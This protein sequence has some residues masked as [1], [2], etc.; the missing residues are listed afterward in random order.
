MAHLPIGTKI[1]ATVRARS[2]PSPR[3]RTPARIQTSTNPK[4]PSSSSNHCRK[5]HYDAMLSVSDWPTS[6]V[7]IPTI[8]TTT[9]CYRQCPHHKNVTLNLM[10]SGGSASSVIQRASSVSVRTN[11]TAPSVSRYSPS[12]T[13]MMPM[14]FLR[15]LP[16]VASHTGDVA[17]PSTEN[18]ATADRAEQINP[19]LM[20]HYPTRPP[21]AKSS[22]RAGNRP[23]TSLR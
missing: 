19:R 2:R 6:A 17:F 4:V 12:S 16:L 3:T 20:P 18:N 7:M 13:T 14:C 1:A 10:T 21:I 22:I 11:S 5:V 9:F 23:T 8:W 15:L